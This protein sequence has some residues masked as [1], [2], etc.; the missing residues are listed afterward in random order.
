MKK[1]LSFQDSTK[2]MKEKEQLAW[3][4]EREAEKE[5][6]YEKLYVLISYVIITLYVVFI[7]EM[8]TS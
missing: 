6:F 1:L 7:G 4:R 8:K 5:T 2:K 3:K